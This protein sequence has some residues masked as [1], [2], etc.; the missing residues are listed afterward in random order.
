MKKFFLTIIFSL[1]GSC[2]FALQPYFSIDVAKNAAMHNNIGLE[3]LQDGYYDMALAEFLLAIELNPKSKACAVYY[4]NIGETYMKLGMYANAQVAYE[5]A[6]KIMPLTFLY[7]Q[8]VVKSYKMQGLL[9]TKIQQYKV[10]EDRNSL[11]KVMLGLCY[12][13]NGDLRQGIIKLDEFVM[14]EPYLVI[15]SG[16]KKYL[17]E[18]IDKNY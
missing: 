11:Y 1:I 10:M 13:E 15:T 7:Y 17:K 14:Q 18:L 6:I 8:N 9:K 3:R 5:N 12:V 16:V 2:V 4:N